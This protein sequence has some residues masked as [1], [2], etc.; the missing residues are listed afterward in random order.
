MLILFLV[1]YVTNIEDTKDKRIAKPY[2]IPFW[3]LKKEKLS[4]KEQE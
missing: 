1:Q 4:E 3:H 2:L